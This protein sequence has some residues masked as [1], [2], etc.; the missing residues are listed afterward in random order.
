M[1]RPTAVAK[2][3]RKVIPKVNEMIVP[4][5]IV[6]GEIPMEAEREKMGT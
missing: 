1:I 4:M 6:V 2:F 3:R 5:W